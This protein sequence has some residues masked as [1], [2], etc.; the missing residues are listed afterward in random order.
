M[1]LLRSQFYYDDVLISEAIFTVLQVQLL[2]VVVDC[3]SLLRKRNFRWFSVVV[4]LAHFKIN[5]LSI[6][7]KLDF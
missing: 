5:N 7:S 2:D 1:S 3:S 6:S 4:R